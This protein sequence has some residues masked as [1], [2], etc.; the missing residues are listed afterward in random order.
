MPPFDPRGKRILLVND[1]GMRAPGLRALERIA[2][3]LSD[4][5]W[6]VAPETEQSG[7]GHSLTLHGTIRVA[8]I[9]RRRYSV[10]GSPTDCV[11]MAV[12]EFMKDEPPDMVLSGVNRGLNIAEDVTYSGTVAAA[13]EAAL[14]GVPAIA[15]SQ[16]A[17]YGKRTNWNVARRFAPEII[18]KVLS[19]PWRRDVFVNVNFPDL[20]GSEILGTVAVRQGR[21]SSGYEILRVPDPRE[22]GYYLIGTPLRGKTVGRGDA[23]HKAVARG[24]IAVTPLH[25]DMTHAGSLGDFRS[26]FRRD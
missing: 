18:K 3:E 1:D 12:S 19:I 16:D 20:P 23:D 26:L 8:R 17:E 14:L 4:D 10:T 15:L 11:L 5:I 24:E 7:A 6:V 13:M 25:V 21:R 9:G 2:R 22:K